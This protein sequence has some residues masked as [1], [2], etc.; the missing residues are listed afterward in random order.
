MASHAT[1]EAGRPA[2]HIVF[3]ILAVFTGLEIGASYLPAPFKVPALVL[4][5]TTKAVLVLMFFMH[6]KYDA[7]LF[8][9]AFAVGVVVCIPIILIITQVMPYLR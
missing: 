8:A 9:I 2:Y 6:L 3:V 1:E 7:R 4:L 5:A